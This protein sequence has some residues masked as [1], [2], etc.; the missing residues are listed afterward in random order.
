MM[1]WLEFLLVTGL[2]LYSGSR[3]SRYG[4]I[5]AE[6]TGLSRLWLGMVLM[7]AVT[8]LPELATGLSSVIV[9]GVSSW[10]V[11]VSL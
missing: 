5:I 11:T 4:D 8:S 2:I 7:A 9:A 3:L 10:K 1:I 6:K